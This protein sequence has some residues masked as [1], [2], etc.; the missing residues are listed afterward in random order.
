MYAP[1]SAAKAKTYAKKAVA[2]RTY[3]RAAPAARRTYSR[4]PAPRAA[5]SDERPVGEKIGGFLGGLAQKAI[6][7]ITG[8]GDYQAPAFEIA[9]NKLLET[10][11]PPT[12]VNNGKEFIIRHREYLGDLYATVPAVGSSSAFEIQTYRINPGDSRAFPWLFSVARNFEQYEIQGML[13][14]YKSNY[15]DA[16]V[17]TSGALGTVIIATEYNSA[18]PPF[19]NKIQMENYEFAQ[20][21]KPSLSMVHPVECARHQSVLSELYIRQTDNV[22]TLSAQDIKTY[23]FGNFQVA[24][25]GIP[26][27]GSAG[28]FVNLGEIWCTYQIRLLKPKINELYVDSGYALLVGNVP[29]TNNTSDEFQGTWTLDPSSNVDVA[30]SPTNAATFTVGRRDIDITYLCEYTFSTRQNQL[31][32][33]TIVG[34]LPSVGLPTLMG[35]IANDTLRNVVTTPATAVQW[36]N[37]TF[38]SGSACSGSSLTFVMTVSGM[39]GLSPAEQATRVS[40][41]MPQGILPLSNSAGFQGSLTLNAVPVAAYPT[42][43]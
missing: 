6:K 12:V 19:T 41:V 43:I 32:A 2:K 14:E 25:V 10:N 28:G 20:S 29:T 5:P 4:A 1:K 30:I 16:V 26:G 13:W 8:F 39:N 36:S 9:E 23:D 21:A 22:S 24:T 11:G 42:A 37:A 7:A 35:A 27:N 3:T 33:S 40:V 18:S 15:S 34:E 31:L 17:T 38:V